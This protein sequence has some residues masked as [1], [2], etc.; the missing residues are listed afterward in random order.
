MYYAVHVTRLGESIPSDRACFPTQSYTKALL[1]NLPFADTSYLGP[2]PPSSG[3]TSLPA[4]TMIIAEE[5]EGIQI[6]DYAAEL[7]PKIVARSATE[8]MQEG[9]KRK[10]R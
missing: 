4:K 6:N 7:A 8:L 2:S 5:K 9:P 3:S 1:K 10:Q